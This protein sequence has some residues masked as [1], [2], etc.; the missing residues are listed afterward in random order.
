MSTKQEQTDRI[1]CVPLY[2]SGLH[3]RGEHF[4]LD[5]GKRRSRRTRT[6]GKGQQC[7]RDFTR[8]TDW[9]ILP[10]LRASLESCFFFERQVDLINRCH[11][12]R[13]VLRRFVHERIATRWIDRLI[14]RLANF[15][16]LIGLGLNAISNPFPPNDGKKCTEIGI[17]K[18]E[19]LRLANARVASETHVLGGVVCGNMCVYTRTRETLDSMQI[20][21]SKI[22]Q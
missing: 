18:M 4:R 5:G 7:R 15:G 17:Q 13:P 6:V 11:F 2:K 21:Q 10:T 9:S 16:G 19:A 20:N 14:D 8:W 12:A 22:N 3:S 1:R